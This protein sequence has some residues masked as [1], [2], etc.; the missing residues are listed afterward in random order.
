M[1]TKQNYNPFTW[2][3][4][5]KTYDHI[6]IYL[7]FVEKTKRETDPMFTTPFV[8]TFLHKNGKKT[9]NIIFYEEHCSGFEYELKYNISC[10]KVAPP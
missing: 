7:G 9:L 8:P 2:L 10:A 1:F 4:I 6:T 3:D 5:T